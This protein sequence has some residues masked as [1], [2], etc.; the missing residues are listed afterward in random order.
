[1][2]CKRKNWHCPR[3][4]YFICSINFISKMSAQKINKNTNS[5]KNESQEEN[6]EAGL[7]RLIDE[8]RT[9]SEAYKKILKSLNINKNKD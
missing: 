1:M 2:F 6:P 8:S 3:R 7:Q 5:I 4:M 9:K